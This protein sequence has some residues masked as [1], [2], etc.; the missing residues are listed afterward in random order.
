M[1]AAVRTPPPTVSGT[2]TRRAVRSTTSRI[3]PRPSGAAEMSRKHDL[4][5]AGLRVARGQR[6]RVALVGQVHEPRRP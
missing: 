1:S 3:V 4:V 6:R 5:R 2:N